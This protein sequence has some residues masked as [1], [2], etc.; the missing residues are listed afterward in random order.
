MR[1]ALVTI[2]ER[3]PMRVYRMLVCVSVFAIALPMMARSQV[4]RGDIVSREIRSD[5]D[6]VIV[7]DFTGESGEHY[8]VGIYLAWGPES[9]LKLEKVRGDVGT[10]VTPGKGKEIHWDMKAELPHPAEGLPYWFEIEISPAGGWPWYYY[11]GGGVVAGV[12]VYTLVPK[13]PPPPPPPAKI[14]LPPGGV[15]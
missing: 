6:V 2:V 5:D 9:R 13:S 3:S 14:P 11:A 15:R 4:I 7:Y 1:G 12:L 10:N 8:E